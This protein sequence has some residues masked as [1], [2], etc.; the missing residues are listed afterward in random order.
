MVLA[1]AFDRGS[2]DIAGPY[3]ADAVAEASLLRTGR[4]LEVLAEVFAASSLI[5][6]SQ[7]SA[8]NPRLPLH[9]QAGRHRSR[10][11]HR[12]HRRA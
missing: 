5:R 2:A 3:L 12:E 1:A 8:Q 11:R 9:D 6:P 4:A 10:H 7:I